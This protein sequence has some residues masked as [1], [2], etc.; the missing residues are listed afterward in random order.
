MAE[1]RAAS[2]DATA[3]GD[4]STGEL[5]SQFSAQASQLI[6]G[7][8]QLARAEMQESAKG[9][10]LGAGLFGTAGLVALYGVGTLIATIVLALSLAL[11]AW[12]AALITTV[13]LFAIAAVAALIGK[14]KVSKAAPLA[15]QQTIDNLKQDVATVKGERG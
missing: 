14:G 6:R 8:L 1:T 2:M 4:P 3:T 5:L 15:P 11:P 10:G 7:E 13:V 9:L 12:L